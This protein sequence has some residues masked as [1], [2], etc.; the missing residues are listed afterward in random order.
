MLILAGGSP[1]QTVVGVQSL[2]YIA[3]ECKLDMAVIIG[4]FKS[5]PL[6]FIVALATMKQLQLSK[7]VV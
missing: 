7:E 3:M 6:K 5:I 1:S 2:S 4:N